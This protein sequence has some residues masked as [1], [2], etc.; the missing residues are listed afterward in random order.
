MLK[1]STRLNLVFFSLVLA[2]FVLIQY[3][4]VKSLQDDKLREFRSRAIRAIIGASKKSPLNDFWHEL[5][6]TRIAAILAQSFSAM[7]LDDIRVEFS[8]DS[9]HDQ[10]RSRGFTQKTTADAGNLVLSYQ[11]RPD[12]QKTD[13]RLTVVIPAW[14]QIAL[15]DMQWVFAI[16]GLLTIM[17]GA[18]FWCA[19]ILNRRRRQYCYDNRTDMMRHLMQQLEIPL[20]TLSVA[21]E[22]LAN[23]KVRCNAEKRRFFQQ[24]IDEESERMNERVRKV[25]EQ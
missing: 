3:C 6:D 11:L 25:F 18:V 15:K 10:R 12:S 13:A 22:A 20:S 19:L 1:R 23:E 14:K 8:I 17:V 2:G 4:W 24:V 9:G 5:S 7:G 16:C 21:V